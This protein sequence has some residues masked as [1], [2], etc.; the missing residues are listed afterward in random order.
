VCLYVSELRAGLRRLGELTYDQRR[1]AL[2]A[3][4]VHVRVWRPDHPNRFKIEAS[5]PLGDATKFSTSTNTNHNHVML[6]WAEQEG[7]A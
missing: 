1:L 3:L 4:G 5:I 2:D 7:A 6:R